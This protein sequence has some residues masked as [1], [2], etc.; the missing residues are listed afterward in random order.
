MGSKPRLRV[1]LTTRQA[2]LIAEW[3]CMEL[4]FDPGDN[5]VPSRRLRAELRAIVAALDVGLQHRPFREVET[6]RLR[7]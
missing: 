6:A 2:M 5:R 4:G 1:M 3:A 7:P